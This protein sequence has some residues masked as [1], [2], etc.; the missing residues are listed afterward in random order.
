MNLY[1]SGNNQCIL[2]CKKRIKKFI[3]TLAPLYSFWVK[4][5]LKRG[6]G[7]D[8][9][10]IPVAWGD[11]PFVRPPVHPD[12]LRPGWLALKPAWQSLRPAWLAL[13]PSGGEWTDGQT[14]GRTDGRMD[15]RMDGQMDGRTDGW[16]DGK[17]FHS[18][19]L[20]PLLGPLP[21]YS[22]TTS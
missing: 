16:T 6:S 17:S 22:P 18:T 8:R 21:R 13:G 10:Q 3:G 14:D 15:G 12:P 7:P 19:G 20:C 1:N 9:G 2:Y 5:G 11:F 4:V